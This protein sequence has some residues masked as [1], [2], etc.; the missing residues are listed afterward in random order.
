MSQVAVLHGIAHQNQG[1]TLTNYLDGLV[2]ASDDGQDIIIHLELGGAQL[3]ALRSSNDVGA[4]ELA[5]I[6]YI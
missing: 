6:L 4:E 1:V 5:D 3:V 2:V